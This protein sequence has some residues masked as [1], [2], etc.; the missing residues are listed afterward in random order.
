MTKTP[1]VRRLAGALLLSMTVCLPAAAQDSPDVQALQDR[2]QRLDRELNT[3][4]Q[5]VYRG[6]PAPAA[7]AR[8]AAPG[9]DAQATAAATLNTRITALEGELRGTNG[10]IE[11]VNVAVSDIRQRLDK[12]VTDLDARLTRIE[13]AFAE[14]PPGAAT[15]VSAPSAAKPPAKAEAAVPAVKL[16]PGTP[17]VQYEFAFDLLKKSEYGQAEQALKQFVAAH[18]KDPLASNAQY[19]LAETYF[20][21][22]NFTEAAT[23]FLASYQKY[24]QATKAPDSLIKLGLSLAKLG[25]TQAACAAFARFQKEYPTA[26]GALR[27]RAADERTHLKCT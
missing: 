26:T 21:R 11:E 9:N 13:K 15:Q 25:K 3:V 16:P 7:T 24:P 22:N 27:G 1:G 8:P 12:L 18:P 6:T 17:K 4:Q 10:Q 2:L 23:Q 14:H 19:W 20:V 5:Q